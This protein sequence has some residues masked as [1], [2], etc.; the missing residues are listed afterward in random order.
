MSV[1]LLLIIIVGVALIVRTVSQRRFNEHQMAINDYQIEI[2]RN[3]AV[4]M[5]AQER[6]N[7]AQAKIND[8]QVSINRVT[9]G[10]AS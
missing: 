4:F 5:K 9:M 10:G 8:A 3:N 6:T 1:E 2:N 7:E